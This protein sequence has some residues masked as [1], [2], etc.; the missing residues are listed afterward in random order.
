MDIRISPATV[1]EIPKILELTQKSRADMF[2]HLDEQWRAKKAEQ[3]LAT[4]KETF[5][6]HPEGAFL[7]ARS[8]DEIIATIGYQPYDHRFPELTVRPDNV[9]EVVRLYV[10]PAWRRGGLASRLVSALEKTAREAGIKQLYLHTHPFLPGA[11]KFWERQGFVV[12]TVD[13]DDP[14]WQT[15]HM[16]RDLDE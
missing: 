11:I 6:N 12:L 2:P 14:V 13:L 7:I 1:D 3:D 10:L 9:V 8:N 16:S 15:T 4:F 5:F